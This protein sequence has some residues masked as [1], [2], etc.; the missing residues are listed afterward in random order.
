MRGPTLSS[1]L[2]S[3]FARSGLATAVLVATMLSGT[4]ASAYWTKNESVSGVVN[5]GGHL[6]R[7]S[8]QRFTAD[9]YERYVGIAQ[10]D[11]TSRDG[12]GMIYGP[13]NC[14]DW[15]FQPGYGQ[16]GPLAYGQY[17]YMYKTRQCWRFAARVTPGRDT[18]GI[19][20]GFGN[21]T[22][23]TRIDY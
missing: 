23:Y 17:G 10:Y 19:S 3:L 14:F 18:N 12:R 11:F 5:S 2:K 13:L 6:S 20:F 8:T 4:P 7:Y 22:W 9:R 1:S 21:T 16:A 15:N